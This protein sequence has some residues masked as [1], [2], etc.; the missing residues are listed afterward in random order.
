MSNRRKTIVDGEIQ[1]F[2]PSSLSKADH[3]KHGGCLKKYHYRYV[4]GI[5]E[6]ANP[7]AELGSTCHYQLE[8][9]LTTGKKE[10]NHI[11]KAGE[12][13]VPLPSPDIHIERTDV[14]L[15]SID[16]TPLMTKIDMINN[17]GQWITTSGAIQDMPDGY[18]EVNDWK[19]TGSIQRNAKSGNQLKNDLQMA[20]YGLA[21][22]ALFPEK[23]RV[24]LSHT[25]FQTA[26]P[27]AAKRTILSDKEE[28]QKT[29]DKYIP[30]AKTLKEVVKQKSADDVPGNVSACSAWN[31]CHYKD[32]CNI[33][34]VSKPGDFLIGL[35]VKKSKKETKKMDLEFLDVD[36]EERAMQLDAAQ[37][38][39]TV[40]PGVEAA[41][42]AIELSNNGMPTF[43]GEAAKMVCIVKGRDVTAKLSGF[44]K[45]QRLDIAKADDILKLA[46]ELQKKTETNAEKAK[47]ELPP[48]PAILPPNAPESKPELAA[49]PIPEPPKVEPKPEPEVKEA[50]AEV[51]KPDKAVTKDL[52]KLKKAEL[53][54]MVK[55]LQSSPTAPVTPTVTTEL[56]VNCMPTT[57]TRSLMPY[58]N[59]IRKQVEGEGEDIRLTEAGS[60]GKWKATIFE[61]VKSNPLP[62]G[63]YHININGNEITQSVVGA[64]TNF[65]QNVVTA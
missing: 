25:Y 63:K 56:F 16:G 49:D 43:T 51:K 14:G 34:K 18:I 12:R 44:G 53:V 7:K 65:V 52:N 57:D 48:P 15:V 62:A 35:E 64:L 42:Q 29:L 4:Q 26:K 23:Q 58:V 38:P 39:V 40:S 47:A 13:F 2:S 30:L 55:S 24:R 9:Y 1:Y 19:T 8:E 21:A 17:S 60:Y 54:E 28:L 50:K 6:P 36:V 22:L 59:H 61:A 11:V 45:L 5:R 41:I 20:S 37:K 27:S 10:F 32:M 31:G 3:K 46:N 33:D